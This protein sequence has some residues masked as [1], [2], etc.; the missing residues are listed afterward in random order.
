[1]PGKR[2]CVSTNLGTKIKR[3][4]T[5]TATS[6]RNRA[7]FARSRCPYGVPIRLSAQDRSR[8]RLRPKGIRSEH[9][10]HSNEMD[11]AAGD[12]SFFQRLSSQLDLETVLGLRCDAGS[13]LGHQIRDPH[14]SND[15]P[16]VERLLLC[17][18]VTGPAEILLCSER[19]TILLDPHLA[20]QDMTN[21]RIRH[22]R[23]SGL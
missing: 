3:F 22:R 14:D 8:P 18:L 10:H 12:K 19:L 15:A 21:H 23:T 4:M 1:V 13:I 16:V 7:I 6:S 2:H 5:T 20:F 11:G 9:R 17:V